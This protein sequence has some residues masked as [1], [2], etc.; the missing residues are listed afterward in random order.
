MRRLIRVKEVWIPRMIEEDVPRTRRIERKTLMKFERIIEHT[1]N[2]SNFWSHQSG[3]M[4]KNHD[5]SAMVP[6]WPQTHTNDVETLLLICN[7]E[8]GYLVIYL[9]RYA[10]YSHYM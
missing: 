5:W 9:P 3:C 8:G 1:F 6:R 2:V 10:G 7:A 4:Y